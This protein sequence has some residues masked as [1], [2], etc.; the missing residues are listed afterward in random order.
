[1]I[2]LI[3]G[4]AGT[5]VLGVFAILFGLSVKG[6]DRKI[7][8]RMQ[9]RIGPP[10]RQPFRDVRKLLLK[11]NVLPDNA[12]PW[13]YNAAPIICLA[14]L[15]T[16]LLF[17]PIGSIPAV[18]GSSGDIIVVLYL[19]IV[20]SI[21]IIVGGFSSGSPFASVG[22]QREM[23]LLISYELPLS[24]II[25]TF[26]W[27]YSVLYP[28]IPALS[29]STFEKYPIW[30]QFSPIGMFG[31]GIF[32]IIAL[33]VTTAEMAKIPFD[34]PEAE[35]EIAEGVFVEYSGRNFALF[36]LADAVKIV[37]L[38]AIIIA[39]F[40]PYNLSPWLSAYITLPH[41][42]WYVV[43]VL[44]FMLKVVVLSIIA[45]TFLRTALARLKVDQIVRIYWFHLFIAGVA[46]MILIALDTMGVL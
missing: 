20:P 31:V 3:Y 14:S 1:M 43:D 38:S 4:I 27:A 36:Y 2:N 15:I 35:T 6:I 34:I 41:W 33:L 28:G 23:V 40:F 42:L 18:L 10:L 19:L 39:I 12:V 7:S 45:V 25:F 26:A 9:W 5:F 32:L 22:A 37:V 11:D 29:F 17:I 8:A 30:N 24:M 13:I 44:F 21:A 46:A 16:I